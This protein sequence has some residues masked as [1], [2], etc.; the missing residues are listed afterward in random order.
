VFLH[1]LPIPSEL[2]PMEVCK[3]NPTVITG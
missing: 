1:V 2:N 3:A